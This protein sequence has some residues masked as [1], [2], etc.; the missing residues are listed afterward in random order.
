MGRPLQVLLLEDRPADAEII[1]RALKAAGFDP[2]WECVDAEQ[3]F[4][5]RLVPSLDLILSDFTLPGFDAFGALRLLKESGM[6]TPLI[7][8][9]GSLGD[10]K[11]VDCLKAG[12]TDYLL[13]DRLARLGSA[14]E[15]ALADRDNRRA[16][17]VAE[18]RLRRSEAQMRGV[19]TTIQDAVFSLSL[20]EYKLNYMNV[21]GERLFGRPL[22]EFYDDAQ[23]WL[24]CVHP[25]DRERMLADQRA[26]IRWGTRE[27]RFRIRR[28]DGS[29]RYVRSRIW[30]AFGEDRKP[31][32]LEGIVS[33]VTDSLRAE[34][35]RIALELSRREG[36]RLRQLSEFKSQ[37]LNMVAH[38]LNN[39]VTP[40]QI[41]LRL[42]AGENGAN[43]SAQQ[44]NAMPIMDRSVGR[45]TS[46]LADLLEAARLQ[47]GKLSLRMAPADL[48]KQVRAAVAGVRTEAAAAGLQLEEEIPGGVMAEVDPRRIEQVITNLLGNALKFTPEGGRIT[49]SLQKLANHVQLRVTD[50]GRGIEAADLPRLFQ[51]FSRINPSSQ[52]KHTGTGLGL[53][54]C[55]GIVEGH[56]GTITC[57][58]EGL[59]K[60]STFVV[61]LP[62]SHPAEVPQTLPKRGA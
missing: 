27:S 23:L 45:L 40:L 13:K 15:R 59:G 12:A 18:E 48:S 47:S 25:E 32:R 2:D 41:S 31:L 7:I 19:L 5:L 30:C 53:F 10:E 51:P 49:V 39:I 57:E 35:E 36:D 22:Q 6:D 3:E 37:F 50:T 28:P 26:G 16:R 4:A 1:V 14:I 42:F 62:A 33:D 61:D 29:I 20:P 60:G 8:V 56:G 52:G 34:E 58:S 9:S 43:L 24:E 46:F 54:I 38:D 11:A 21:A 55:R 17:A 44:A